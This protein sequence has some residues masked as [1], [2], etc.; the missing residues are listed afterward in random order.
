[1]LPFV[2]VAHLQDLA[3]RSSGTSYQRDLFAVAI[4]L[5]GDLDG[6][7]IEDLWIGD[8]SI[9]GGE[10]DRAG[11]AWAVSSKT[12]KSV[13]RIRCPEGARE[14]GWTLAR[15]DDVD[16]D[17]VPDVAIGAQ[18][19]PSES[20]PERTYIED[21]PQGSGAVHLFSGKSGSP[22]RSWSGP[23]DT[24]KLPWYSAGAGPSLACVGDWDADGA[25][26][27][28]IGWCFAASKDVEKPGA[29]RVDV[30]S[31]KTGAVLRSW[32]GADAHDRFGFALATIGDLDGDGRR[33]LA[34][35]AMPDYGGE[36]ATQPNRTKIR[37]SYVWILSSKGDAPAP[38]RNPDEDR[39]FGFSLRWLGSAGP[40]LR[41]AVGQSHYSN[42]DPSVWIFDSLED[43]EPRRFR[44]PGDDA[45]NGSGGR[46]SSNQPVSP[47]GDSFGSQTIEL[48]DLDGDD[49][50]D[51][52]VT[53]PQAFCR[54]PAVILSRK[55]GA[56]V[57][58][59][60]LGKEWL[61]ASNVGNSLSALPDVDGDGVADFAIGGASIRCDWCEGVV[62]ICSGK[63]ASPIRTITRHSLNP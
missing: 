55:T 6:D 25:G 33:E 18:F 40:G 50:R 42:H 37:P 17:G 2:L 4:D 34:A 3:P 54:I 15:I 1:V 7:G 35:S 39:R 29:G 11:A 62:A 14:F 27:V 41:L 12:G 8:P 22:L 28:A 45:W 47:V 21:V 57:G 16:G 61:E 59:I 58:R 9:T 24:P 5:A 52:L 43:S 20:V 23:A 19:V 44:H 53:M 30:V 10:G 56:V 36:K 31:G 13:R 48:G 49:L 46:D 38:L 51:L 60:D 32:Y 63:N 26:D